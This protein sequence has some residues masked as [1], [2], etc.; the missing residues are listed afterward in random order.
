MN[1][2]SDM[3]R[4]LAPP[5]APLTRLGDW[6]GVA[7]FQSL[8]R[9]YHAAGSDV[10]LHDR[11][12]RG[13]LE[14]TG[15]DRAAWLNNLTT[16][17]LA[18]LPPGEGNYNFAIDTKGRILF[19]MNVMI[20]PESIR[21]DIDRRWIDTAIRHFQKYTILEDVEIR[22]RSAEFIRL[23]LIGPH[24][25]DL[26]TRLGTSVTTAMPLLHTQ[27]LTIGGA[28]VTFFR[29]D[30]CGR[31]AIDLLVPEEAAKAVWGAIRAADGPQPVGYD[32][33]NTL[34]IEAGVPW[35]ISEIDDAH[36]PAETGQLRRAVSFDKGCYLGQEIV[37]RMNSR[38][39]VARQL[40]LL[41]FES[42]RVPQPGATLR[43]ARQDVGRVTSACV[44]P[45]FNSPIALAYVRTD[46]S[47]IGTALRAEWSDGESPGRV[48]NIPETHQFDPPS[49]A[50]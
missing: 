40:V 15:R 32:V 12:Y 3:F 37:A 13:L 7:R 21:L 11:S 33:V 44:S 43:G 19:D 8:Q 34:R 5:D 23:A 24:V 49:K 20:L 1:T 41:E 25:P 38:Q 45:R 50:Q 42:D 16:N 36:L 14:V 35:P 28:E 22:D 4:A 48:T 39:S 2:G 17:Q 27:H 47:K 26:M 46:D 6:T 18:T 30:L 29:Q 31:F 10:G 9:E